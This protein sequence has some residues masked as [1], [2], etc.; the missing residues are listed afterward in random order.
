MS[1]QDTQILCYCNYNSV[2]RCSTYKMKGQTITAELCTNPHY[3]ILL[4]SSTDKLKKKKKNANNHAIYLV[5]FFRDASEKS[6][7]HSPATSIS[8][9]CIFPRAAVSLVWS[10]YYHEF[11]PHKYPPTRGGGESKLET[12]GSVLT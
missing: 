1:Q 3:K 10:K 8:N 12:K 9:N 4:V 7:G 5:Q 6:R 11:R 2:F